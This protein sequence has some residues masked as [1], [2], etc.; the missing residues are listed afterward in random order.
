VKVRDREPALVACSLE[1][2]ELPQRWQRWRA[3]AARAAIDLVSTQDGLRLSFRAERGVE[4]ELN[5]L[6]GLERQC[7]AFADWSV[8]STGAEVVLEISAASEE[9]IAAV[10]GMF[11]SLPRIARKTIARTCSG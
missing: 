10:Q 3:L 7:C 8:R 11:G 5:E 4:D 1:Q 9:S 6:A 2:R